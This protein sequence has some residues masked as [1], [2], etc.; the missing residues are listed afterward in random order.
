MYVSAS[1]LGRRRGLLV[2]VHHQ[3]SLD[4]FSTR[5]ER[6]SRLPSPRL[7]RR[8][9]GSLSVPSPPSMLATPC[10]R[11]HVLPAVIHSRHRP[12][13]WRHC[14]RQAQRRPPVRVSSAAQSA[15]RRWWSA[16]Y[17]G[18]A[19]RRCECG[20]PLGVDLS[21]AGAV[22]R[23]LAVVFGAAGS[24]QAGQRIGLCHHTSRERRSPEAL[25]SRGFGGSRSFLRDL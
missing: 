18:L 12:W 9:I 24:A 17:C 6:R 19:I 25:G 15:R 16:P 3:S 7:H 4:G 5:T 23:V 2:R 21:A 8:H 1:V 11:S 22:G 13:W 20:L 10:P 14:P